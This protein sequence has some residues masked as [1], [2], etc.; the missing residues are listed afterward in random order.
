MAQWKIQF[1]HWGEMISRIYGFNLEVMILKQKAQK[2]SGTINATQWLRT[3]PYLPCVSFPMLNRLLEVVRVHIRCADFF[4]IA[5]AITGIIF[6]VVPGFQ[7]MLP[8]M[9]W[10]PYDPYKT[11]ARFIFTYIW[12]ASFATFII[13]TIIATNMCV[14]LIL[15]CL[16]FNYML[17]SQRLQR[18]GSGQQIKAD[19]YRKFVNVIKL[20]LKMNQW[21]NQ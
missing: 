20:H 2:N 18:I 10:L 21:A 4:S 17:L 9:Y 16:N 1:L 14:Y 19:T 7:Y 15:I 3:D 6:I 5:Y 8:M 13:M 11:I 12:Q